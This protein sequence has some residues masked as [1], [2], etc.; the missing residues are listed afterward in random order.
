MTEK[1]K[2]SKAP[3]AWRGKPG[4]AHYGEMKQPVYPERKPGLGAWLVGML[5]AWKR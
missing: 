1:P 3:T 2:P 5:T 4:Y